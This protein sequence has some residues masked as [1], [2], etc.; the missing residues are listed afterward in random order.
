VADSSRPA[1]RSPREVDALARQAECGFCW[2][3]ECGPAFTHL[4]RYGRAYRRGLI[5]GSELA[6]AV[7]R[8]SGGIVFVR[9]VAA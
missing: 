8:N 6:D 4:E 5:T 2:R 7:L 3:P 1:V 9:T